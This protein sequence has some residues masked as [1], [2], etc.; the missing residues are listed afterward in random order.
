MLY[1]T[2]NRSSKQQFKISKDEPE[3]PST[4]LYR[5][6][7]RGIMPCYEKCS[8]SLIFVKDKWKNAG[9]VAMDIGAQ[10]KDAL[11]SRRHH[12]LEEQ[13]Q[14]VQEKERKGI[15][16][17]PGVSSEFQLQRTCFERALQEREAVQEQTLQR[18]QVAEQKRSRT[19]R[20]VTE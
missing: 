9:I 5:N 12:M 14:V 20:L 10:A 18:I 7:P 3:L 2:N 17:K 1:F 4:K 19:E 11:L 15:R 6:L 16:K 13:R 8:L